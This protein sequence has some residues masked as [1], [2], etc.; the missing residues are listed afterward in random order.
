M[1]AKLIKAAV[2]ALLV[3]GAAFPIIAVGAERT[4]EVLMGVN[5]TAK[6]IELHVASGGCTNKESFSIEVDKGITGKPPYA[7]RVYRV[8]PDDCKAFL[9]DGV[10]VKFSKDELGLSGIFEMSLINKLGNTSQ[11]R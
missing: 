7:L 11:H 3:I 8:K 5:I 4:E 2:T 9:L 1:N 10:T 6:E